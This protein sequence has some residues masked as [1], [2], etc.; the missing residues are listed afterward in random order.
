MTAI[1]V[2]DR[3]PVIPA[4]ASREAATDVQRVAVTVNVRA[5]AVGE[6]RGARAVSRLEG[7]ASA[8]T[9]YDL[10]RWPVG[11]TGTSHVA[12][13]IPAIGYDV[14]LGARD[15][16]RLVRAVGTGHRPLAMAGR[17]GVGSV[18]MAGVARCLRGSTT[19]V[20]SMTRR[21]QREI[22]AA[23]RELAAVEC[24]AREVEDA[25]GMDPARR[26]RIGAHTLRRAGARD[27]GDR[28]DHDGHG[29]PC[30]LATS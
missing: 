4:R 5:R 18:A 23:P 26:L 25:R 11:N 8:C 24:L 15:A 6:R 30:S 17:A 12:F 7:E 9:E 1:A 14:T 27:E 21:A 10:G 13:D 22:P 20:V 19:E 2:A 29:K 28:D 16:R 3:G